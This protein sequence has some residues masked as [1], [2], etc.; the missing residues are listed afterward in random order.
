MPDEHDSPK[1]LDE[2]QRRIDDI[3]TDEVEKSRRDLLIASMIGFIVSVTGA[4]PTKIEAIGIEFT[5]VEQRYFFILIGFVVSYFVF[6]FYVRNTELDTRVKFWKAEER[7]L[8]HNISFHRHRPQWIPP[9]LIFLLSRVIEGWH[10]LLSRM[11]ESWLPLSLGILSM[12]VSFYAA[13]KGQSVAQQGLPLP[14]FS[15]PSS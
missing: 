12:A 3:P 9:G 13:F 4:V 14:D 6:K 2:V 10:L 8:L 11:I 1:K 5:K 7:L 15:Y